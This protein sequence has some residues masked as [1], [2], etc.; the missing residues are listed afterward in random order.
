V[1]VTRIPRRLA[2]R[3]MKTDWEI[4]RDNAIA[5][6]QAIQPPEGYYV[7]FSGGKDSCV[8]K[9][10]CDMAGVK[11]D[12]HYAFSG[13]DPPE[14]VRFIRAEHPDVQ[15][16]RH[17]PPMFIL[18]PVKG[19]PIRHGRW[20]CEKYKEAG[21]QGR[22]VVMGV[23]RDESNTRADREMLSWFNKKI[24]FNIII[25]WNEGDVWEFIEH[26][27]IPYCHLYDEGFDRLG[28]I[29][30]PFQSYATKRREFD[31][32]P[33]FEK[34]YRVAFRKLYANRLEK[35]PKAV[36]HWESGDAMFDWWISNKPLSDA[37]QGRLPL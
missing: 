37:A 35:N 25:D 24:A 36:R 15:W 9:A 18:L 30:C 10:L 33:G 4:K 8:I 3:E 19:F 31:R 27:K 2:G 32:W 6:L 26:H 34:A 21:G 17:A 1:S 11:Y 14:L 16:E 29:G 23:R 7:A 13:I 20:C 5:I 12:A 22:I 28:C